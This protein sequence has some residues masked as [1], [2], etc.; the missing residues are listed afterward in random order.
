MGGGTLRG[1]SKGMEFHTGEVFGCF[2]RDFQ[3]AL[4]HIAVTEETTMTQVTIKTEAA[5]LTMQLFPLT[6]AAVRALR[7]AE[8]VTKAPPKDTETRK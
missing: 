1:K 8:T 2:P 5:T 3:S 4:G 7:M 6:P